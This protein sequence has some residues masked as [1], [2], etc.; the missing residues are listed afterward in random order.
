MSPY[1]KWL[2]S[3]WRWTI[4]NWW[5][6]VR[7]LYKSGPSITPRC[8]KHGVYHHMTYTDPP[9]V[10][11]LHCRQETTV[12][13]TVCNGECIDT[14]EGMCEP[15]CYAEAAEVTLGKRCG[16]CLQPLPEECVCSG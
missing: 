5:I 16:R 13:L 3:G 8:W 1:Q 4:I 7:Y 6:G 12:E 9:E 11:C 10:Y 14:D 2:H 15:C